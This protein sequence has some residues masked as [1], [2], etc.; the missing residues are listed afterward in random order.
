MGGAA[1]FEVSHHV[2]GQ[3][4]QGALGLKDGIQVEESL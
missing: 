3:S 2:D 4:F 1:V